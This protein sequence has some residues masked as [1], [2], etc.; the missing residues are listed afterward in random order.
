[1]IRRDFFTAHDMTKNSIR[2][3]E[4]A[5]GLE[6]VIQAERVMKDESTAMTLKEKDI[7]VENNKMRLL[8]ACERIQIIEG[9]IET[10]LPDIDDC[11]SF[12]GFSKTDVFG[13]VG[14]VKSILEQEDIIQGLIDYKAKISISINAFPKIPYET[15]N[16]YILHDFIDVI[17]Y[18]LRG[19]NE[20]TGQP[21][22]KTKM[23]LEKFINLHLKKAKSCL[24]GPLDTGDKIIFTDLINYIETNFKDDP[25]STGQ[26][27][28]TNQSPLFMVRRIW[29]WLL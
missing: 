27:I 5:W 1:M 13:D 22:Q 3:S 25:L 20:N 19:L 12:M 14:S 7:Y 2:I 16:T 6:Q 24:N 26:Y 8:S 17:G 29:P 9:V 10:Q 15:N 18:E 21:H 23:L 4:S 11:F 28:G